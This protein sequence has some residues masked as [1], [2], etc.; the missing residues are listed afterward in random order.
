[1]SVELV[2][3]NCESFIFDDKDVDLYLDGLG[4]HWFGKQ[5][6]LKAEHVAIVI[7]GDAQAQRGDDWGEEDWRYRINKDITQIH[8]DG[9]CYWPVW[10]DGE[11]ENE[12]ETDIVK[13]DA[14]IY[15]ISKTC[16]RLEDFE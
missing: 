16:K 12:Y 13:P 8:I 11:Y 9:Q 2:L 3:E 6:F 5:E 7:H 4:K 1:M 10:G 15:I 14:H